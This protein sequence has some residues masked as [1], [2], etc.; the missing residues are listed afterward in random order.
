MTIWSW[1]AFQLL[2]RDRING[3]VYATREEARADIFD[4]IEM[5]YIPVRRHSYN[6]D[7]SPVQFEK[8][9]SVGHV[10]V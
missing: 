1:R 7:L 2:E 5:I 4:Y 9:F 10:R 6:S 8:Q 3:R